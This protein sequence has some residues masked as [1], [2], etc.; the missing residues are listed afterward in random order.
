MDSNKRARF[1]IALP[2]TISSCQAGEALH[3]YG[4]L[5]FKFLT[6]GRPGCHEEYLE[7]FA[8]RGDYL[9]GWLNAHLLEVERVARDAGTTR[10]T[11]VD[12]RRP[13]RI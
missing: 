8:S 6:S 1:L 9:L 13:G 12:R 11:D 2:G 3:A 10:A 4:K 5:A 7:S